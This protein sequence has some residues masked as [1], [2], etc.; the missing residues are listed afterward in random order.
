MTKLELGLSE[1]QHKLTS[2]EL[3]AAQAAEARQLLVSTRKQRG[4]AVQHT[5][6]EAEGSRHHPPLTA[7]AGTP[8]ARS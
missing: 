1:A 5:V 3:L 4:E 2:H 7:D 8:D 6:A